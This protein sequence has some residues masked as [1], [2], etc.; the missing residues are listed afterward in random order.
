MSIRSR[1]LP[2][3]ATGLL[4]TATG[5]AASAPAAEPALAAAALS[6]ETA[7]APTPTAP[8]STD[9][10]GAAT[11]TAAVASPA[12]SGK[13]AAGTGKTVAL[14]A[15][16]P[17]SGRATLHTGNTGSTG[18]TPAPG[19][20]RTTGAPQSPSATA[21]ASAS[22]SAAPDTV[23]TGQLIASPPTPA[24][25][26]GALFAVTGVQKTDG[27]RVEVTTRP[28]EVAELLGATATEQ[29]KA[30]D[31]HGIHVQPLVKDLKV[32]FTTR[33]GGGNGS[34]SAQLSLD[35]S[36]SV[37]LPGGA[38][39]DLAAGIRLDPSVDFSYDGR[40]I[41][42][43]GIEKARVGFGLG[44]HADWK[45][46][47]TLAASPNPLRVPLAKLSASPVLTVAGFPVV[48][49]LDLTCYLTVG[50][51]GKVTV[52]AEQDLDGAW[53]VHADYAKGKGWTTTADPGTTTVGPVRAKLSGDA[54]LR[55]GLTAEASVGLY[56]TVGVAAGIEPYLRTRVAGSV[57]LDTTGKPPHVEGSWTN[58]A[59]LDINGRL[60]SQI[61]I[62]GTPLLKADLP[63]PAFHREWPLPS[64]STTH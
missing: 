57:S 19:A 40:G 60:Y 1:A 15:Y 9:T 53:S 41:L 18:R 44:A 52:E 22:A 28:A 43:G 31:V 12:A 54:A 55:T 25:P 62:L 51:D 58:T 38:K 29:H 11:P 24:A 4:L 16:D 47:A 64:L 35:A 32:G 23:R 27:D 39:A 33:P 8:S 56:N 7:P 63:L 59:G 37:P 48:V 42:K 36:T 30:I 6:T 3:L 20:S 17:A 14:V 34:A 61:K 46:S 13:P 26:R 49:N 10:S 5:C 21:S 2:A 45:V 50:A